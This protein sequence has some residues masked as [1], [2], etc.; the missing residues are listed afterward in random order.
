MTSATATSSP[1]VQCQPA[2]PA[3]T[4]P[5]ASSRPFKWNQ[6]RKA[7]TLRKRQTPIDTDFRANRAETIN[8]PLQHLSGIPKARR[9]HKAYSVFKIRNARVGCMQEGLYLRAQLLRWKGLSIV[10]LVV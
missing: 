8:V 2:T 7:D 6:S 10:I 9:D 4:A 1:S 3:S 5:S